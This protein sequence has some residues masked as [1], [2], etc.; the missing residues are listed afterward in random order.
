[1]QHLQKTGGRGVRCEIS[2]ARPSLRFGSNVFQHSK[3][4]PMNDVIRPQMLTFVAALDPQD[5]LLL[6]NSAA[7]P[8]TGTLC[9]KP[10]SSR[11]SSKSTPAAF[12]TRSRPPAPPPRPPRRTGF[13]RSAADASP[14]SNRRA[15]FPAATPRVDP[16]EAPAPFLA[17]PNTAPATAQI[18]CKTGTPRPRTTTRA[19][20]VPSHLCIHSPAKSSP[21][22][23]PFSPFSVNSVFSVL[24]LFPRTFHFQLSTSSRLFPQQR[25]HF[26]PELHHTFQRPGR[27]PDNLFEQPRHRRQKLQ[28]A[29]Q[30][31]ARVRIASRV[32]FHLLHALRQH[33]QRRVDFPPLPLL[34]NDP[35]N[36]PH[37]LDRLEVV[38]PVAQHVHHAH[39]PPAL[40]LAQARAHVRARHRQR[41]G[42]LIRRHGPG[43]QKQQRMNLRHRPID[44]PPRAHLPPVQNELLRHRRQPAFGWFA[45]FAPPSVRV[46]CVPFVSS[47]ISV[48]SLY[49]EDT[50]STVCLSSFF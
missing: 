46:V 32:R 29:L 11:E 10:P 9:A 19:R 31:L 1:M 2:S 33:I 30:P 21:P 34:G 47:L 35:E 7:P 20:A 17:A 24:N 48:I 4:N 14:S 22:L 6:R 36:L 45:H 16:A 28:H 12:P 3:M 15:T 25:N 8:P 37:V 41:R 50:A 23:L 18:A 26:A 49:S 38:A 39:D 27:H 40:Q 44:S 5:M 42:N 13:R 43:R